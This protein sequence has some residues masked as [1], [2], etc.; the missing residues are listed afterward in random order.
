MQ[1]SVALVILAAG[2]GTRME[3]PSKVKVM[4]ELDGKPMIHFAV[5]LAEELSASRV[6]VVLGYQREIVIDYLREH[7]PTVET[8]VQDPQLGTGHAVM[9]VEEPLASFGGDVIVISGDVPLLRPETIQSLI[10]IHKN[11]NAAAT[12]LTTVLE[13]PGGYGRI[14]RN[15]NE[16]VQK[17]VEHRDANEE[18]LRIKE[19]NS[20]IY[21]FEKDKLFQSLKHIGSNNSQKEYYLTD[22]FE[23]FWQNGWLVSAFTVNDSDEVRGIN[24]VLQLEEAERILVSRRLSDPQETSS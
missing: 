12:I 19:I 3:D 4:Y 9:Q 8:A 10:Q 20:G 11:K 21:I 7:H 18:E 23:W 15:E 13:N 24:T 14:I 2:K 16:S 22:V 17:I 5:R 1:N 6:L